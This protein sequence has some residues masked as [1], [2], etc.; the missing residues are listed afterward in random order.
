[1]ST[2][3]SFTPSPSTFPKGV[4]QLARVAGKPLHENDYFSSSETNEKPGSESISEQPKKPVVSVVS[5]S[6]TTTFASDP[7]DNARDTGLVSR[8]VVP[9]VFGSEAT[10]N[11]Q[12]DS[13][14]TTPATT[15]EPLRL[16][17]LVGLRE[18]SRWSRL[19]D[20][21]KP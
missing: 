10:E 7:N 14:S 13:S 8:A 12:N 2:T 11:D 4:D 9:V 3:T 18:R 20:H 16:L 17:G 1:M 19:H 15:P 5:G 21:A 6:S